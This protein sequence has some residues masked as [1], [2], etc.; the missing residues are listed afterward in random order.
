MVKRDKLY[1]LLN[2]IVS[3]IVLVILTVVFCYRYYHIGTPINDNWS[4][5]LG[6]Y[7]FM[8]LAISVVICGACYVPI[9]GLADYIAKKKGWNEVDA[10]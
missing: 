8:W 2:V 7:L 5:E 10:M 1:W 4:E 6:M 9:R 3:L